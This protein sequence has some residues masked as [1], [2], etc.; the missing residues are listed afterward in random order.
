M[1]EFATD[2]SETG[3]TRIRAVLR[4]FPSIQAIGFV[5]PSLLL[6]TGIIFVPMVTDGILL[7]LKEYTLSIE[8]PNT[9]VGL[10]NYRYWLVGEGSAL[11][12]FSVRITLMFELVVMSLSLLIALAVALVMN[13]SL[14]ARPLWR[15]LAL[16][17]YASP[18][19]AAGLVFMLMSDAAVYGLIYRVLNAVFPIPTSGGLTANSPWAFWVVVIAK[20]WRDFG[21]MYLVILAAL[22]SMPESLHEM[23]KVDGAGPV[24][25]FRYVTLPHI[26]TAVVT[27][28]MIRIVDTLGDMEM[29]WAITKG[30]PVNQTSV[31]SL[32]LFKK[33]F[34][35]WSLGKAAALGMLFVVVS[36]PLIYLWLRLER[37]D[38][39]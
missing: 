22:Q 31:L 6:L 5:L 24:A 16:A 30:G 39:S 29:V 8:T 13:E 2:Q 25:R 4:R 34:Q 14:P 21:F 28:V 27:V 18:A 38:Q 3:L 7:S 23:A 11:F 12:Q 35:E 36:V 19:V 26:R 10:E 15:G 20:V 32:L 37:G 9:W 33:G 1:S 17:S